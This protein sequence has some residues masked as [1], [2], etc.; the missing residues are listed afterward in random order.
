MLY[1]TRLDY[2][3]AQVPE[4]ECHTVTKEKCHQECHNA[5]WCKICPDPE[6][7]YFYQ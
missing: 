7:P 5:Y 6:D 3:R 2:T 1:D 4:K